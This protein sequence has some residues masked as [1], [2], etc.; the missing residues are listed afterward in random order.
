[1]KIIQYWRTVV[2]ITAAL[3]ILL[4]CSYIKVCRSKS[5]FEL[6]RL[7]LPIVDM[8]HFENWNFLS[9]TQILAQRFAS[10]IIKVDAN[11]HTESSKIDR[12]SHAS[13]NDVLCC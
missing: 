7:L 5:E 6:Y 2:P 1:M 8:L 3:I 4:W 13:Q 9:D 12:Q 10:K 11:L